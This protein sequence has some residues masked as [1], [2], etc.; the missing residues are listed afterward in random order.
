[1]RTTL[2][3]TEY[4]TVKTL[5][6]TMTKKMRKNPHQHTK[7]NRRCQ[8]YR[9]FHKAQ[10]K[11]NGTGVEDID[12]DRWVDK[13]TDACI[14]SSEWLRFLS[15]RAQMEV[16]GDMT[17]SSPR[18]PL[19]LHALSF[20]CTS[21]LCII[22]STNFQFNFTLKNALHNLVI[23]LCSVLKKLKTVIY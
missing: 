10:M 11:I 4:T 16:L 14:C 19:F 15:S 13:N 23:E 1:M 18:R 7:A 6:S 5:C 2:K 12:G 9:R 17:C 22:F 8:N 20:E 21:K 3:T